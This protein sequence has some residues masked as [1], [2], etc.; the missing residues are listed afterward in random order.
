MPPAWTRRQFHRGALATAAL[1]GCGRKSTTTDSGPS[2]RMGGDTTA[3]LRGVIFITADDLGWK[4]QVDAH[5]LFRKLGDTNGDGS[6]NGGD[7]AML[8]ATWGQ[9]D[10]TMSLDAVDLIDG[11]DLSVLLANW[12]I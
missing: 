4:D 12:G 5:L 3:T 7:L 2:N 1:A 10:P 8:L 11:R 9:Q 6:I